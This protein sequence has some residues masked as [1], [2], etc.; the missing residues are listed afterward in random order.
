MRDVTTTDLAQFGWRERALAAELLTASIKQG[1]PENFEDD[2]VQIMF[3]R[4]SG[5][6]FF[7]NSEYEVCLMN[8]DKLES[9]YYTPFSGHE[10]FAEDLRD[11]LDQ[12][13]NRQDVEY[14]HNYGIID[15][16]EFKVWLNQN[17]EENE[18]Y[19]TESV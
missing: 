4:N 6:V 1:F 14:L 17:G 3:N 2:G 16:D 15:D 10:G 19:A 8:G 18:E 12:R 9:W 7:T 13:W 5:N 11:E